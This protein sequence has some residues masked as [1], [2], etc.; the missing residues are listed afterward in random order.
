MIIGILSDSHKRV[1]LARKCIEKL[2]EFKV[3]L[4]LHAGDIEEEKTLK[5]LKKSGVPYVAVLGN[6]DYALHHLTDKYNL[7]HEPHFFKHKNLTIKM[8]HHP[9]YL[10]PDANLVVFG[11]THRFYSSFNKNTLF[12]NPGEVCARKEPIF[13]CALVKMEEQA[14]S[15]THLYSKVNEVDWTSETIR[16]ERT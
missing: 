2:C 16:Y 3:E 15:V 10:T 6:N 7:F 1:D 5:L 4:L 14:C 11:H 13:E 12:I 8:M 9:F